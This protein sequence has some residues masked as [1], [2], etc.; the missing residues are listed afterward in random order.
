M[1]RLLKKYVNS[2]RLLL[3]LSCGGMAHGD[4]FSQQAPDFLTNYNQRWVDS[5]FNTLTLDQKVGQLLMPRGNYSGKAHNVAQLK[6]WVTR[7]KI[8]G[9]VFFASGPVQQARLTNELQDLADVPL[10]IGQDLEWGLGMRLDSTPRFPYNIAIGAMPLDEQTIVRMGEEIG[11][12]CRRIGVHINYAPV[13]DVNNNPQNPVINFRSFGSDKEVVAQ[14]GLA[15]MRGMQSQH[16]LC[17]AKHFPGHG[18]T[19]V[20]S[21]YAL[22]LISH[23][24][25]RLNDIELYPFR[26]LIDNGLSGIMTAHLN[27]P[28]LEPVVGL[29]STFSYNIVFRLL[30]E[31]LQFKGLTF[32]DAMEMEGA[33][34]NFPKG[35]S[36][37]RALLAGNDILETFTEV[38]EAVEAIKKAV[39]EKRISMDAIDA[40]VKK[41]L[42]AKS[43]VGLDRY[44]PIQL[45]KLVEDVN[46]VESDVINHTITQQS[47][48]CLKNELQLL[49]VSNLTQRIAV[50]TV[51]GSTGVSE[52][53]DMVSNYAKADY[54]ILSHQAG[55]NEINTVFEQLSK[56]DLV[57]A[58]GH[59]TDIRSYR[60]YG[61]T[62]QNIR[63]LQRLSTMKQVVLSILGSPFILAAVPELS[64]CK[65]LLMAY[66]Q[67]TYTERIVP[68]VIFGALPAKGK[69]PLTL[70]AEFYYG[71]GTMLPAINRLSYTV[72]EMVGLDRIALSRDLDSLIYSGLNQ[73]AYPGCVLQVAKDGKVIFEKAYGY[74]TYPDQSTRIYA[75]TN[76]DYSTSYID[77]AMDN[78]IHNSISSDTAKQGTARTDTTGLVQKDDLYDLASLTKITASALALMELVS[79]N[80]VNP[81]KKLSQYIPSLKNSIMGSVIFRD[82][83]THRAGLK[84]WIPFWKDAIDTT[85]TIHKALKQNPALSDLAIY[86]IKKP[87]FFKRLFGAKPMKTLDTIATLKDK[88]EFW[89]LALNK[90]TRTWKK[91]IFSDEMSATYPVA[92]AH[93]MYL[94][95]RYSDRIFQKIKNTPLDNPGKYVYSDLHFYFYPEMIQYLTGQS[96]ESYLEKTYT[97]LGCHDLKFNPWKTSSIGTVIPT[98]YDSIFRQQLLHGYV[99]DEGAAML[100]GIS[101]HAGL[102]GTANDVIRLMQMYLWK[103]NYGHKQYI[104]PEVLQ[105][106]TSC[107]FPQEHNRRGLI[108]DKKGFEPDTRNIPALSS[109]QAFGHSGF[110]GT[111]AW[112]DPQ[113]GLVYVF[114]SNRV[115]PTR[116]NSVLSDLNIRAAIGDILIQHIQKSQH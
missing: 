94:H 39:M 19:D 108:F 3:I 44:Q 74:H 67:S 64:K 16:I 97:S 43:W 111:Y 91:N 101:G 77:D 69:L 57:L 56:Y 12:Q 114:L 20:D 73:R 51:G 40:R 82:A 50:L 42:K 83:L 5:V 72:P 23:D 113:Y 18:D 80:K 14:N 103:G 33:V 26:R 115:Y 98:E 36:M 38:P 105:E 104:R 31:R 106:F 7:Y 15:L 21:H 10:F 85:A 11:R 93:N 110:T 54:Y 92:V 46:T 59:F 61:L 112:A 87:G 29:A 71:M 17:T 45:E 62:P 25:V 4:G 49:P 28:A 68:Q 48:T 55:D 27:I 24:K 89:R 58:T 90:D 116:Y 79:E 9:I 96:M 66:Q 84:P 60:K 41:I 99:H 52:F 102:F 34:K 37:V 75:N 63:I 32:T 30:R 53:Y 47:I 95:Q 22:P 35:E 13:V 88:P 86:R 1:N 2:L 109:E 70:N 76:P 78:G 65:S 8:G 107:Q 81:E 6:E 100:G